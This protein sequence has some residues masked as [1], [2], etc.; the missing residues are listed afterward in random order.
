MGV[1]GLLVTPLGRYAGWAWRRFAGGATVKQ[2]LEQYGPAA[3]DRLKPF[4]DAADI[5]YPP[6]KLALI[7]IKE[8]KQLEVWGRNGEVAFRYVRTYPVLAASG[9]LGP[10]LRE[11]DRQVPEGLYRIESLHPNSM[12]HLAL[13]VNYPNEADRM[14]A[15]ADGRSN[16]GGDIMIHGSDAS[17]GCLAMGDQAAEDL[18]VLVADVGLAN[19]DLILAPVDFRTSSAAVSAE[20][21]V[22]TE[23]RYSEIRE[24]MSRF[25]RDRP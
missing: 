10:K 14:R 24:R 1:I 5:E 2:R 18:F 3:R 16:L 22:W 23:Q 21:P 9:R 13:R 6:T 11:G 7:G 8:S 25:H 4:F 20:A 15:K 12:F 19:T 17:A